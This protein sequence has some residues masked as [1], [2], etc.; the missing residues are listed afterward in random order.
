MRHE[1]YDDLIQFKDKIDVYHE[2]MKG[3]SFGYETV[4]GKIEI[5]HFEDF[6]GGASDALGDLKGVM[7]R[8]NEI[9][10]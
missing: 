7:D 5:M 1:I 4:M 8:Y 9:Q 2:E 3:T 6:T 10:G